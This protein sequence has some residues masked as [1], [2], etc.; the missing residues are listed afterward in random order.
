MTELHQPWTEEELNRK[1]V[2]TLSMHIA[3]IDR[4]GCI[5][6][7]NQAWKAFAHDNNA[8]H[9][10]ELTEGANYCDVCC[11]AAVGKDEV[12]ASALAGIKA[13]QGGTLEQFTL[14]YP[15]HSPRKKQWF[16]MTVVPFGPDGGA[17]ITHLDIT[18][19][20]EAEE[21]LHNSE[22][23]YRRLFEDRKSTL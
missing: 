23:R 7:V 19:R 10:S 2:Q 22:E 6:A 5:I 8:G 3:V 11:R 20:K 21:A 9:L 13:V 18:A 15:C 12:A 14:E 4:H 17:L 16:Y 1:I